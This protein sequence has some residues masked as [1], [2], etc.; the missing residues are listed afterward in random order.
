MRRLV[1]FWGPD[2]FKAALISW[3]PIRRLTLHSQLGPVS[4]ASGA[5]DAREFGLLDSLFGVSPSHPLRTAVPGYTRRQLKEDK[6]A[7]TAKD[8][9]SWAVEHRRKLEA[10]G[11]VLAVLLL[12]VAGGWYYLDARDQE[13]SVQ[14]GKALR[15]YQ[16]P[17][18]SADAPVQP[19]FLTYTSAK[20]RATAANKEF[21][22][23]FDKYPH[24]RTAEIARYFAGITAMGM[25][26]TG[27]AERELKPLAESRN[28]DLAPLAR[29]ALASVYRAAG[30]D[31]SA[32]QIYED[33]I[34]HP[35]RSVPKSTAQLELASLY[36]EKQPGEAAR[37]YEQIRKDDPQ[38][39]AAEIAAARMASLKATSQ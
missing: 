36:Q 13:A 4:A 33:L 35:T 37:I 19:N 17:L 11:I 6:F 12:V 18:R 25:G 15:I 32:I 28:P 3:R 14:M 9:F 8:T 29:F 16:A 24:T 7:E 23:I 2:Q 30:R 27:T 38:G 20:E 39:P 1:H 26:D 31:A 34:N 5:F 10:G 21:R 22:A